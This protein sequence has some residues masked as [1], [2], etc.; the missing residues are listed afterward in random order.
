ME[1][2]KLDREGL[3]KHTE[4]GPINTLISIEI[5]NCLEHISKQLEEIIST[6]VENDA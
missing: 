1:A 3:G 4:N 5:L 2:Y 6:T